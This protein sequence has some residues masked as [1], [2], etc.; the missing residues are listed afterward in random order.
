MQS[1]KK[2]PYNT[3]NTIQLQA[4]SV[5]LRFKVKNANSTAVISQSATVD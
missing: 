4:N 2:L 3:Y 1:A 5:Q